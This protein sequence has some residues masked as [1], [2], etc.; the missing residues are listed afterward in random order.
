VGEGQF[1]Y[2]GPEPRSKETAIL[3]IADGVEARARAERPGNEE[4]VRAVVRNV[5]ERCQKDKQ[6]DHS[7]LSQ[8]DLASISESIISTLQVTYH[9]RLEYPKEQPGS[10]PATSEQMPTIPIAPHTKKS[11]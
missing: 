8:R 9:R 4:Q 3:M 2:P 6:L 10:Q 5:I 7:P 11:K 1:R